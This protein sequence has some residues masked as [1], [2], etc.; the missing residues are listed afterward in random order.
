[1]K[2]F[3]EWTTEEKMALAERT[4]THTETYLSVWTDEGVYEVRNKI[5]KQC[6]VDEK[7]AVTGEHKGRKYWM[8]DTV[9]VPKE[10][11]QI[12]F[13]NY[14]TSKTVH[15]Y[16]VEDG[17]MCCVAEYDPTATY[18]FTGATVERAVEWLTKLVEDNRQGV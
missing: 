14:T 2:L 12:P 6:L 5:H 4:P 10:M 9:V 1:M 18:F 7:E 8:E 17:G 13:P 3:L 16:N 15:T 11:W